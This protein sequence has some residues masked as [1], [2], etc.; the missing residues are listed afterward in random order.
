MN[1]WT[2]ARREAAAL[3]QALSPTAAQRQRCAFQTPCIEDVN[4]GL[5]LGG[6][7]AV[8]IL[9]LAQASGISKEQIIPHR[10]RTGTC[11]TWLACAFAIKAQPG[12]IH[13]RPLVPHAAALFEGPW[14]CHADG[15][16]PRLFVDQ[17]GT[18]SVAVLTTGSQHWADDQQRSSA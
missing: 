13:F 15:R 11:K 7:I 4:F 2:H 10:P 6:L 8:Q 12:S 17:A 5:P 9:A 1:G 14:P 3:R 18:A 16:F